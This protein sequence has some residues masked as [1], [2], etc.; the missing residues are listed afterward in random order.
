MRSE[1]EL[2]AQPH[3]T[4]LQAL[5]LRGKQKLGQDNSAAGGAAEARALHVAAL[6][7]CRDS[8]MLHV[9]SPIHAY[10]AAR[11]SGAAAVNGSVYLNA[12]ADVL[13]YDADFAL[14][15]ATDLMAH[16]ESSNI[17]SF[18][19][20]TGSLL[21]S[22]A[23]GDDSKSS[24][25]G[26]NEANTVGVSAASGPMRGGNFTYMGGA[27]VAGGATMIMPTMEAPQMD[28]PAKSYG[29][30]SRGGG[31]G[32]AVSS[33]AAA[34]ISPAIQAALD[35]LNKSLRRYP[36][37]VS[38]YVEIARCYSALGMYGDATR[39]LTQCLQL[40]PQCAPV[41]IALAKVEASKCNA[42]A[43]DRH[44][45][46]ALSCD[47]AVRS[48]PL[49]KLVKAIVRAQQSR[50]DEAVTEIEQLLAGPEFSFSLSSL[51]GGGEGKQQDQGATA[52]TIAHQQSSGVGSYADSLRLTEDDRVGVYVA[53]ASLLSKS[54]RLKEA[55]KVLSHAKVLYSGSPQEVQVLVA[56]SQLYV[57]KSD[58][59]SAIRMLDKIPENSPTYS[60][61]QL[62][63]AD[64]ILTHN[65]DKEG[66]TK[67]YVQLAE[68]EPSSK[69]YA[70]LGEAYLRILNPEA[71]VEALEKAFT[72]DPKNGRLRG[73][74]GRKRMS[75]YFVH[76]LQFHSLRMCICRPGVGCN[77]RVSPRSRVL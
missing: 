27:T 67:C 38:A 10:H 53:Y 36:G 56:A 8:F 64:I 66:F 61:A 58:F 60:R 6:L 39:S 34:E 5:L 40:Q 24:N 42:V 4:Y 28:A 31:G 1:Q 73:R 17:S 43:A 29:G 3:F 37:L 18:I 52:G 50:T 22:S 41:L 77:S 30:G 7:K 21:S 15:L 46:Q 12:F 51:A 16:L 13:A 74:I 62:I 11:H 57:E 68:R 35:L 9:D 25:S 72:R 48:I 59:D 69:H 54:R 23:Q 26:G 75:Y 65:H 2:S 14:S 76:V 55:N 32:G 33:V 44:L 71:A 49:F 20:S 19:T 63:K 47:F 70:L 45:E